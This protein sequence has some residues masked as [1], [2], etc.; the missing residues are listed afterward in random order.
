MIILYNPGVLSS[1][2]LL[3]SS[4]Q[5]SYAESSACV[6]TDSVGAS[7]IGFKMLQKFGWKGNGLGKSEQGKIYCVLLLGN[8][9]CC[10]DRRFD[11]QYLL[12][13]QSYGID[14]YV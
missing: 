6:A 9:Q 11:S 2:H 3:F 8:V 10:F 13:C 12:I 14:E 7:N 4:Q 1:T 5:N